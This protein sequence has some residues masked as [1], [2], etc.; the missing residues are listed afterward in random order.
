LGTVDHSGRLPGADYV[1]Y[2]RALEHTLIGAI[3]RLGLV[4]GQVEGL[5]GVWIQ[6]ELAS[7]C[8]ACPPAAR[9]EPAKLASIGVKVDAAGISRHGFALNVNPD[10]TYW[11]GIQA[12]GLP[13]HPAVSL[14]Q[15]LGEAP[16]MDDVIEAVLDAFGQVFDYQLTWTPLGLEYY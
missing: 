5:T 6:P 15:L 10:M 16:K 9:R 12:C 11:E 2:L 7:R 1:G 8:P 13:D 4:S 3:A 14:E